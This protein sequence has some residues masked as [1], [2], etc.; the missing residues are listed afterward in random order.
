MAAPNVASEQIPTE[1]TPGNLHGFRTEHRIAWL[2]LAVGFVSGIIAL[3][4]RRSDWA[5]GLGFGAALGWLN[6]QWMRR[7]ADALSVASAAQASIEKPKL[8]RWSYVAV[9]LRYGLIG[10][11]VYVIFIYLHVPLASLVLGL[12]ALGAATVAASVWEIT[13]SSE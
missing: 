4:L 7:G 1:T 11:G 12:C 3:S 13:S 2:T 8:P 5:V 6:F 10:L 9:P